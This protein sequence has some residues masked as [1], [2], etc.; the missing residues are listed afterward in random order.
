MIIDEIG[1]KDNSFT[2]TNRSTVDI[3]SF[4]YKKESEM[5][6][7]EY[8]KSRKLSRYN[9]ALKN[10][11]PFRLGKTSDEEMPI[12]KAGFFS[13][14]SFSWITKYLWV[15][16]RKGITLDDLPKPSPYDTADHNAKRLEALWN[17]EVMRNGLTGASFS[18]AAWKFIR[19]RIFMASLMFGFSA[20]LGFLGPAIV[21]RKLLEYVGSPDGSIYTGIVWII[22]LMI[23]DLLR[24]T[25][26]SWG[27]SVCYRTG[28]RMK[29]AFTSVMYRKLIKTSNLSNQDSGKLINMMSNDSQ[30]VYDLCIYTPMII[31]GPIITILIIIYILL[32][33]SPLALSGFL[34][35]FCFYP[36]QYFISHLNGYFRKRSITISDQR[37]SAV[38]EI[39]NCI[40]L[41]KMYAW[42]D[43]FSLN[44]LE[45]RNKEKTWLANMCITRSYGSSLTV[46]IPMIAA[47]ISFLV[48]V[49][50]GYSLTAAQAFPILFIYIN[51]MKIC[52]SVIRDGSKQIIESNIAFERIKVFPFV[53]LLNSQTRHMISFFEVAITTIVN[54]KVSFAR[55]KSIMCMEENNS[56]IQKPIVKSQALSIMNGTFVCDVDSCNLKSAQKKKKRKLNKDDLEKNEIESLMPKRI[57]ILSDINFEV[58]KSKLIGICGHVGSGK[59]S[60]LRAAL[61][62]IR[63]TNGKISRDGS[64]AYVSQ[65]AWIQNASLKDN[66]LFGHKFDSHRYYTAIDV[67]CLQEDIDLLPAADETEIGERGVNLSGGQKQRVALAR[68]YYAN[69]DIYFLDDPL[70]AV[71]INVGWYIFENLIQKALKDKSIIFVTHKIPY[72]S[73]CDQIYMMSNGRIVEQGDHVSL[74]QAGKEYASMVKSDKSMMTNSIF[75]NRLST[76]Y[77]SSNDLTFKKDRTNDESDEK[78]KNDEETIDSMIIEPEYMEKGSIKGHTYL[79]YISAMGGFFVASIVLVNVIINTGCLLFSSWWLATWIKAG[80]G[81]RTITVGNETVVSNNIIDNPDIGYYQI[82]YA[83]C[84]LF[85]LGSSLLRGY[86][87]TRVALIA[88]TTLHNQLFKKIMST[89]MQFF[90]ST[91]KGRLQNLFSRDI[92][93]L[94]GQLPVNIENSLNSICHG[95]LNVLMVCVI[96]PYLTIPFI[97]LSILFYFVARLFRKTLRDLQRHESASK[98]PI[99]SF[100][101]ATLQGLDTIHA[102]KKETQFI[103]KFYEYIDL[104]GTC[105]F[106]SS[107]LLRWAAIRFDFLTIIAYVCTGFTVVLL[108]GSIPPAMAGLALSFCGQ[109][110]GFLQY[111]IRLLS[112]TE[113]KFISVERMGFY[114]KT[115]KS[116]DEFTKEST[117]EKSYDNWPQK[118]AIEFKNVE[119]RY[120][121]NTPIILNGLSFNVV[122][123]EKLGIVGRTSAGKSSLITAL[124]RLVELSN[125]SIKIDGRD[126]TTI[127]L[128]QLRSKLSIIPQDPILFNGSVRYNL[129]PWK[130]KTDEEIWSA[131]EITKLKNK[132]LTMPGQ[133]NA[134]VDSGGSNMSMGER[135]LLCLA[136]V[137]LRK[138]KIII[139]DEATASVDPLTESIVQTT[140]QNQFSDC[141][142]MIIAH[143]LQNVLSCDRILVLNS[144][145][146]VEFDTPGNLLDNPESQ[147][148]KM[149]NAADKKNNNY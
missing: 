46:T 4:G 133:L 125:G 17:D 44:L 36:L 90:E 37:V 118:G 98:S 51:H 40:K 82:V 8:R 41:I 65:Q 126:I 112:L 61:G 22:L 91:P 69:Q 45:L 23:S 130:V 106:L 93:E 6:R 100:A 114:L 136:R 2:P 33:L 5:F 62:Q 137:L 134:F 120:R 132:V 60:L 142:I 34:F 21:M 148:S 101:T 9:N 80:S 35:F 38:T 66:I 63:I 143:R 105:E 77:D 139:L 119:L 54:T 123:G 16:Y 14:I 94:D 42:E 43:P 12:D 103:E 75:N 102:F 138:N 10:L 85:I 88:S 72:L 31:A 87:L 49:A 30:A 27:W 111:T 141:T 84:I 140:I 109:M 70:S 135:Q 32:V 122:A 48:H 25:F 110:T 104:N 19:T 149:I 20:I 147:F 24:V 127:S 97:L 113:L 39:F 89:T 99:F 56:F 71:D 59:S 74:L 129:D 131:L 13:T 53:L 76:M 81:G 128:N 115:L 108:R 121:K 73:R 11:I 57:E 52:L 107:V 47:I 83:S 86:V 64:C 29:S 92:S 145:K 124:F 95:V 116:E 79:L 26:F 3:H 1:V 18:R 50:G 7:N 67:C 78:I 55:I 58:A 144:G 96:L 15:S 117:S 28:L 68:A 146:I